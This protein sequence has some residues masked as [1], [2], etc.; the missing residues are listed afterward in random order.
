MTEARVAADKPG[1]NCASIVGAR[2]GER[3]SQW[4]GG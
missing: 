3:V 2:R 1:V 4:V